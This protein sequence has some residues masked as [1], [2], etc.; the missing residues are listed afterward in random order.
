MANLQ[1]NGSVKH[2]FYDYMVFNKIKQMLGGRIRVM[3]TGS[4]PILDEVMNTT[5]IVFGCPV[6][7]GYGMSESGGAITQTWSYDITCA[8][9][10]GCTNANLKLRLKDV[11]DMNYYSTNDPP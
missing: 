7:Q 10:V 5:K 8:D 9:H 1:R 11:P 6:I 4:A 2:S 3:G